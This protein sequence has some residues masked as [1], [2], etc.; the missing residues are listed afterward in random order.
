M[1]P[2][3]IRQTPTPLGIFKSCKK[4]RT[5]L[6]PITSKE[7]GSCIVVDVFKKLLKKSQDK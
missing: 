6:V 2:T 1:R 7:K 3:F 5:S 4:H